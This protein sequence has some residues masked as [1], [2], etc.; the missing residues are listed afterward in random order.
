MVF[1]LSKRVG[2]SQLELGHTASL[3]FDQGQDL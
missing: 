1:V 2:S 3:Q